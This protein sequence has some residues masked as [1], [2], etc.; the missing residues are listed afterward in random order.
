M[1]IA[2]I[3][4]SASCGS[5]TRPTHAPCCALPGRHIG[6][7]YDAQNQTRP[8]NPRLTRC[9][10][11]EAADGCRSGGTALRCSRRWPPMAAS[12]P[13][14]R[15]WVTATRL[16]GTGSLQSIT[17]YPPSGTADPVRWTWR[18]RGDPDRGGTSPGRRVPS[19]GR[20]AIDALREHRARGCRGAAGSAAMEF[21]HE[22]QRPQRFSLRGRRGHARGGQRAGRVAGY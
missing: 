6:K 22:N 19:P 18:R 9:S 20:A 17:C 16:Y 8:R 15:R 2:G 3:S 11:C 14:R 12:L 4:H 7:P 10:F 21:R 13:P 5:R 1:R